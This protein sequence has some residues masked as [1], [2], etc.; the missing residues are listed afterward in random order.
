M[1]TS[2]DLLS[3]SLLTAPSVSAVF[4]LPAGASA[5]IP[6]NAG[7]DQKVALLTTPSDLALFMGSSPWKMHVSTVTKHTVQGGGEAITSTFGQR[8]R[9]T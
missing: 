5:N 7:V 4:S 9:S 2:P 3:P 6:W 1:E 8:R